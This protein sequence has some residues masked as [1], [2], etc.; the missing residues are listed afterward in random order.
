MNLR[1]AGRLWT[2]TLILITMMAVMAGAAAVRT[3]GLIEVAGAAQRDQQTRLAVAYQWQGQLEAQALRL[4]A[5]PDHPELAQGAAGMKELHERMGKLVDSS[6][7]RQLLAQLADPLKTA[8][9]VAAQ[10]TAVTALVKNEEAKAA[11]LHE[12]TS[13]ERMRTVWG[14]SGVMG[15]V[16][17]VLAIIASFQ[18][19]TICRPLGELAEAARRVGE[20]DLTVALDTNRPDE[21]GDVMRSVVTMR[22]GLRQIVGQ[23]Q[24]SVDSIH[25]ASRE[26]SAGNLDLSQRTE[27]AASNLQRTAS[28]MQE[29]SGTM[30]HSASSAVQAD[31]LASSASSVAQRGGDAMSQVM[32]TMDAI[33]ASSRK[34]SD[35]IGVIDGI[36]FQTNILAL[37]AA[38]EAARA[39][40]QGR[41]FA[42]VAGEVRTLAGR[43]AEAAREIKTLINAS[44]EKVDSGARQVADASTTM[45]EIVQSVQR[46]SQMI[47]EI[48]ADTASQSQGIGDLHDAVNELDQMT[49]QNAALVE[50]SAA[51]AESLNDQAAR[52]NGVVST[53]RLHSS[54]RQTETDR[55][56]PLALSR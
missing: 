44:V 9:A 26:V 49:Q 48:T 16:A 21:I 6:E 40:E 32:S 56:S 54:H 19:R 1:L 41:G 22:D 13:A 47:R 8:A 46:V 28:G 24:E 30:H 12:K 35:I 17:I 50:Q 14:V 36:A 18:V 38:V 10:R 52:L 5:N 45:T 4:A 3:K 27:R 20:G 7:E 37:N 55:S 34:I 25:V 11:Q 31:Q 43:S 53:F 15:I 42:V 29:L 33:N 2:P 51:A 39:G 23:V